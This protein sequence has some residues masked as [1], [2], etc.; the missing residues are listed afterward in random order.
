MQYEEWMEE[1]K[2][3]IVRSA[4][5]VVEKEGLLPPHHFYITFRTDYP[6]VQIPNVLKSLYPEEMSIS[7]KEAFWDLAVFPDF[8][9]IELLFDD[10]RHALKVP[11]KALVNFIDPGAEFG[12]QFEWQKTLP[13]SQKDNVIFIDQFRKR[14]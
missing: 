11:F 5:S 6:G 13:E 1:G 12:L 2:R 3:N 10:F 4:L 7:I 14:S 9:S 8:F